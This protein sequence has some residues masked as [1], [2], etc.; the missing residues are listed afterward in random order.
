MVLEDGLVDG[1]GGDGGDDA[2]GVDEVGGGK[3]EDGVG[4]VDVVVGVDEEGVGEVELGREAV[5]LCGRFL[6]VD[7]QNDDFIGKFLADRL[8]VGGFNAAGA[9]PRRPEIEHDRLAAQLAEL[10][11]LAS[12]RGQGEIWG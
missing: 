2:V 7:P 5:D 6:L 1:T 12:G 4:L 11:R 9:A 3:A 8:E 10:N